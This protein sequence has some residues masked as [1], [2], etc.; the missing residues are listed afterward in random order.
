LMAVAARS[1]EAV[2]VSG[3]REHYKVMVHVDVEGKGWLGKKGALPEGLVFTTARGYVIGPV[4]PWPPPVPPDPTPANPDILRGDWCDNQWL[5]IR[6]NDR[7]PQVWRPG[8]SEIPCRNKTGRAEPPIV[9]SPGAVSPSA[10]PHSA[11]PPS[12]GPQLEEPPVPD[13]A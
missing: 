9:E 10:D 5:T 3:R 4:K 12:A 8:G 11:G 2:T 1:L 13:A 6:S 7:S